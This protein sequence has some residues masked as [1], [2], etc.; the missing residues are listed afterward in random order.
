[1]SEKERFSIHIDSV[2]LDLLKEYCEKNVKSLNEVILY[3][4]GEGLSQSPYGALKATLAKHSHGLVGAV[5]AVQKRPKV[6]KPVDGL[7]DDCLLY[8]IAAMQ[9]NGANT[10]KIAK[11]L[12]ITYMKA[13]WVIKR[14]EAKLDKLQSHILRE[15]E[16]KAAI[17][18]RIQTA[19]NLRMALGRGEI[20]KEEFDLQMKELASQAG[21]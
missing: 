15:R 13:K 16:N 8:N 7:R 21:R 6:G 5:G 17:A 4:L 12:G 2:V 11:E 1:M 20:S 19:M 9:L 3:H 14:D 18:A 10:Y